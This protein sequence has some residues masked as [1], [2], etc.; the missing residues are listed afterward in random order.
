MLAAHRAGRISCA[1]LDLTRY[2]IG[3]VLI[4][5]L[6]WRPADVASQLDDLAAICPAIEAT[7]ADLRLAAQLASRHKLTFYDAAYA[8]VARERDAI[9][10]TTDGRL[11]RAQL[12]T[13]PAVIAS[14]LGSGA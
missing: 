11:L 9:L 10:A 1:I 13:R 12:G 4:G 5:A 7:P 14:R 8:A 6:R 3:N 2:E